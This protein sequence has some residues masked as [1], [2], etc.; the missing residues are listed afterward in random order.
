M[1]TPTKSPDELA[2][3]GNPLIEDTRE[4]TLFNAACVAAFLAK[5]QQ[6]RSEA[7]FAEEARSVSSPEPLNAS[8]TRGLCLLTQTLAAALW[9][10]LEGRANQ[11]EGE[12]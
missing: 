5:V 3:R 7:L 8:E 11:E 1:S 4:D 6:D 2:G 10:S 9:F 12:S